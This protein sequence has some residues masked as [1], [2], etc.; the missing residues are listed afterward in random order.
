[1]APMGKEKQK[2]SRYPCPDGQLKVLI[3]SYIQGPDGPKKKKHFK[4]KNRYP[5]PRWVKNLLIFEGR[6]WTA[7]IQGPDGLRGRKNKNRYPRPRWT[8]KE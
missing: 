4:K 8:K 6:K 2:L 1:M 5:L 3:K 7:A